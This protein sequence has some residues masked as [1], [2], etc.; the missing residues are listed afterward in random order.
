MF[1]ALR[2]VKLYFLPFVSRWPRLMAI[3]HIT[4]RPPFSHC[5]QK[6]APEELAAP[7][8]PSV[9]QILNSELK[10]QVQGKLLQML[11]IP[12]AA[13]PKWIGRKLHT[14]TTA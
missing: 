14:L 9:L 3:I 2:R 1:P 7:P 8:A 6:V 4:Y 11:M 10:Q 12:V 5:L 13:L